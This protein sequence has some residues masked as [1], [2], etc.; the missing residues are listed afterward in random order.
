[1]RNISSRCARTHPISAKILCHLVRTA[2]ARGQECDPA[3]TIP[4]CITSIR[5]LTWAR[6][7]AHPLLDLIRGDEVATLLG[8]ATVA[9]ARMRAPGDHHQ[10]V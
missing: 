1:M 7:E 4:D 3:R 9:E 6:A 8:A 5:T 10:L 2:Q